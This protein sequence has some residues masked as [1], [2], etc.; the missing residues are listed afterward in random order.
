VEPVPAKATLT[1]GLFTCTVQYAIPVS[2]VINIVFL[3]LKQ[4]IEEGVEHLLP[5]LAA[6]ALVINSFFLPLVLFI[7]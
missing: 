1:V 7:E 5:Q 3:P 6:L 2:V 4:G